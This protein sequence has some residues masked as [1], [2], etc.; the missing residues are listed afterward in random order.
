MKLGYTRRRNGINLIETIQFSIRYIYL[1]IY[2]AQNLEQP[3]WGSTSIL[4]KVTV[5]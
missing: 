4:Q 2:P 1:W 5:K 3:I